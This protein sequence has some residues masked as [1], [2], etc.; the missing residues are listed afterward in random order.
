[1]SIRFLAFALIGLSALSQDP[2]RA[3]SLRLKDEFH[4]GFVFYGIVV[5]HVESTYEEQPA[6]GIDVAMRSACP[7]GPLTTRTKFFR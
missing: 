3:C 7:S 6:W 5:G 4:D 1:M 2:A